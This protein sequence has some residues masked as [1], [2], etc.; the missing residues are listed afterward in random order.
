MKR[1]FPII[2]AIILI[3]INVLSYQM[4]ARV[5]LT[6]GNMYTL[7]NSTKK[8]ARD[9]DTN[10]VIY[11]LISKKL[12]SQFEII[13]QQLTDT[14]EEY[15]AAS[16]G[17]L[18]VKRFDPTESDEAG[19]LAQKL[20]IP[21]LQMQVF[22]KDQTQIVKGYMGL[23]IVSE[24][25]PVETA[26]DAPAATL[27]DKVGEFSLTD[28]RFSRI[29]KFMADTLFDENMGGEH[30]NT[31]IALGNSYHDCYAGDPKNV[32]PAQ[33]KNLGYN[34]SSVHTDIVSTTSRVVTATMKDGS[35]KV[36]YKNGQF[37]L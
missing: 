12:P 26:A 23:A 32:K 34:E 20:G 6:Q 7:S 14:I 16:K 25:E 2:V 8:I 24:E 19:A 5:D 15:V 37:V 10:Y 27:A 3:A 18:S 1:S 35:T 13:H 11:E 9:L 30:G 31:H 36:I 17:K 22:E 33:W 21:A 28:K 4:F 29:T